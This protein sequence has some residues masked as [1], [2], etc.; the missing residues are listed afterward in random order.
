MASKLYQID[1][2]LKLGMQ[3]N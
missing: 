3:T 2:L 1:L